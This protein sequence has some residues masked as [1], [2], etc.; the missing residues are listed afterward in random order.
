MPYS[1]ATEHAKLLAKYAPYAT[2]RLLNIRE[3]LLE[4]WSPTHDNCTHLCAI[5]SLLTSRHIPL[6]SVTPLED[7][8]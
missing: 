8:D 3:S 7:D 6:P 2:Q 4:D 1:P 5:E